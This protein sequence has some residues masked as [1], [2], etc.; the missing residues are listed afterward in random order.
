MNTQP[1][2]VGAHGSNFDTTPIQAYSSIFSNAD[3]TFGLLTSIDSQFSPDEFYVD[4][5]NRGPTS[6]GEFKQFNRSDTPLKRISLDS[7]NFDSDGNEK[8]TFRDSLPYNLD[9]RDNR[10]LVLTNHS[11]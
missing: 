8:F 9:P 11:Y 1:I 5:S 6:F 10:Y 4:S 7:P 2:A 3:G